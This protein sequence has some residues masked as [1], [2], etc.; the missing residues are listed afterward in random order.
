MRFDKQRASGETRIV[1]CFLLLF[2]VNKWSESIS[3][4]GMF[5]TS[6]ISFHYQE[7]ILF[8]ITNTLPSIP[9][10]PCEPQTT[11]LETTSSSSTAYTSPPSALLHIV[12]VWRAESLHL[13]HHKTRLLHHSLNLLE[14]QLDRLQVPLIHLL[15]RHVVRRLRSIPALS[16]TCQ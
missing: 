1:P 9:L 3:E 5:F 10:T 12:R 13:V 11:L 14:R 8:H 6:P 2:S 7:T 16:P 4:E 15:R